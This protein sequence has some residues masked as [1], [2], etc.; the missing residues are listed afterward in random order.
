MFLILSSL[1]IS[2]QSNGDYRTRYTTGTYNWNTA[3]NWQ[4]YNGTAWATATTVPPSSTEVITIQAGSNYTLNVSYTLAYKLVIQNTGT[5]T[6]GATYALTVASGNDTIINSGTLT[7]T[8]TLSFLSGSVYEHAQ[9]GGNIPTATWASNSTCYINYTSGTMTVAPTGA[10][11]QSFGNFIWNANVPNTNLTFDGPSTIAGNL[12]V[13][14]TGNTGVTGNS[15]RFTQST[16]TVGGNFTTTGNTSVNININAT[17][18][19]YNIGG[20]FIIGGNYFFSNGTGLTTV[21]FTGSGNTI[22]ITV[23]NFL[24]FITSSTVSDV[25]FYIANGA[26]Y[27]LNSNFSI[28]VSNSITVDNGGTLY[29]GAYII[30]N[31]ANGEAATG[32]VF[33]LSTGGTL[34][35]GSA[36]GITSYTACGTGSG[37]IQTCLATYN[38]GANYIYD[39]TTNQV[40]GSG[41]TQNIPANITINNPGNIVSLSASTTLSSQLILTNGGLNLNSFTLYVNNPATTAILWDG[42]T[43]LGY[44]VSNSLDQSFTNVVKWNIGTTTGNHVFPFG[45]N[46]STYIPFTFNLSAGATCGNVQVSTYPD[47]GTTAATVYNDRPTIVTNLA[48]INN[49]TVPSS[50]AANIVRRFW[51]ITPD[52]DP[53]SGGSATITF[54]YDA[55]DYP[56]NGIEANSM[57]AQHYTTSTNKWDYPFL[58]NQTSNTSTN[59]V[60]VPAVTTLSPWTITRNDSPL[61]IKLLSF[62]AACA[63]NKVNLDWVT[64]SETNNDYFTIEK[65]KDTYDWDF[66]LNMSGAGNSNSVLYYNASDDQPFAGE[67][68]YRLKQTDFNGAYTYS[69]VVAVDCSSG[70][71]FNFKSAYYSSESNEINLVFTASSGDSYKYSLLNLTGQLLQSSS[72]VAAAG[73]NEIL[74]NASGLNTGIYL[75][76][77]QNQGKTVSHKVLVN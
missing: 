76:T 50:D 35:I 15:I 45:V 40:T 53:I 66:V 9:D 41:L 72:G 69:N 60:S 70:Q 13:S 28:P 34:G 42:V 77:L 37:N 20:N 55:T 30:N 47:P 10:T 67:S 75:V 39:G 3:A 19:T 64:A 57:A 48:S 4:K 23:P 51:L 29:M 6:I 17:A 38:T 22:D 61:P 16:L 54:T 1:N 71:P 73:T 43:Y 27:T 7:P 74:I 65:S 36:Q 58:P 32:G 49:S 33:T 24:N 56:I 11:G 44:I 21:N 62:N 68:Y 18:Q 8:G 5:L 25:A 26:T 31:D 63:D 46:A 14:L 52:D 12:L 2:A 59:T